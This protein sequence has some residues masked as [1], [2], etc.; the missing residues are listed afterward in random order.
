[1]ATDA[2]NSGQSY[3]QRAPRGRELDRETELALFARFRESGDR[4]AGEALVKANLG[5]VAI[6]ARRY[7]RYGLG[8]NE[9]ISEG[10]FGLVQA[11]GKFDPARGFRFMTYASHWV[12]ATIV[13]YVIRSHSLVGGGSSAL[14]SRFFFKLRRE[15]NRLATLLGD[16]EAVE[17]ALAVRL[18]LSEARV[19]DMLR[20]LDARDV[21]LDATS[22][23]GIPPLGERLPS[24]DDPE[25]SVFE[26]EMRKLVNGVLRAAVVHLDR[27]ERYILEHRL[28]AD[29][30]DELSLA[31]IAR[32]LGV[33][34]ER[35]RQLEQRTKMKLKKR[36]PASL[37]PAAA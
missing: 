21:S 24:G 34:R 20:R 2:M 37:A 33:S 29:G 12:R 8:R 14:R 32:T 1:M 23:E 9:L 6:I 4:N 5:T 19:S 28:M 17:H 25:R 35:A 10:N 26:H 22:A 16:R 30:D 36:M 13:D 31:E 7:E 3:A 15:R 27:R 18:G 11:L